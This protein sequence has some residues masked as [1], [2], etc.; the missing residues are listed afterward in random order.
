MRFE[1]TVYVSI[2]RG[3]VRLHVSRT[4]DCDSLMEIVDN[5]MT[6]DVLI[7]SSH[8]SAPC[9]AVPRTPSILRWSS[10]ILDTL[11]TRIASLSN[12]VSDYY[13]NWKTADSVRSDQ[14]VSPGFL[15]SI[16]D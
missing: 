6:E 13:P 9:A 14:V 7:R 8:Q 2:C 5:N 11:S 12:L 15:E 4:R 16:K 1:G 3:P 10:A